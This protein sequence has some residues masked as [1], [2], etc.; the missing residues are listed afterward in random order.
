MTS[1]IPLESTFPSFLSKRNVRLERRQSIHCSYVSELLASPHL[2]DYGAV[3]FRTIIHN[4]SR[5]TK[6]DNRHQRTNSVPR[7][8]L[9]APQTVASH[10]LNLAALALARQRVD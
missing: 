5:H 8:R 3:R 4:A 7:L 9:S 1:T 2:F 6:H 10:W